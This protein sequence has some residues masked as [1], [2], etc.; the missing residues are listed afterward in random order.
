MSNKIIIVSNRLPISVK[1]NNGKFKYERTV[2]GLASGLDSVQKLHK[3]T[4]VGWPGTYSYKE[5]KGEQKKIKSQLKSKFNYHP[6]FQS[7]ID[8]EKYYH[9][10]S[11]STLWPLFHYFTQN[12]VYDRSFWRTYKKVNKLFFDEVIRIYESGDTIWIHDYHLMMLPQMLRE[13]L[14]KATIGF[15]L[16]IPFPS[17]EI[18]RLLPQREEVLRGLLG[19][20]VVGF[21]TY[22]Y[23]RHFLTSIYRLLGY[24]HHLGQIYLGDRVIKA[25]AFPIGIDFDKFNKAHDSARVQKETAKLEKKIGDYKVILS[26]DRLDYTKG[27]ARR[28]EAFNEFLERYPK[29]KEK[30]ILILVVVPSRT[31]INEYLMMKKQI[32]ELIGNINGKYGDLDWTPVWYLYKG[33]DFPELVALYRVADVCLVTPLRDGMNLIAKEYIASKTQGRGVL[34]LSEMVGAAE[35]LNEALIINP[36]NRSEIIEAIKEA[37][38]MPKYEQ[39]KRIHAIQRELSHFNE[40]LWSKNFMVRLAETKKLQK[41]LQVK[42]VGPIITKEIKDSYQKSKKRLLLLDY[43]GTLTPFV[44]SP[45]EA[46]PDE[47]LINLLKKLES[48]PKN[49][50]VIISG[51]DRDTLDKWFGDLDIGLVAEHGV[52]IRENGNKWV[53]PEEL[54]SDWKR[55]IR[56]ILDRYVERTPGSFV[57]EK[58]FS[59]VW[60]YRKVDPALG[61]VRKRE[62]I[63]VLDDVTNNFNL[64]I[65]DGNK[66]I[67]IKSAS[68]NKG[69]VVS[70]WLAKGKWDFIIALGDDTTDEDTFSV[71]PEKAFSIKVGL[72]QSQAHFNLRSIKEVRPLLRE[73]K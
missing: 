46:K 30:V 32:D 62:L 53:M 2:G 34:I 13:K 31:K 65:L 59:L 49:K 42:V 7:Q 38:T 57:E 61:P 40:K 25:D 5:D 20:D 1:K 47:D 6:V 58:A 41:D 33:L 19:A 21:Q 72:G 14:P 24:D 37:L 73:L 11:N 43:D 54:S 28:L 10:Y 23:T 26:I 16:H 69:R 64:R 51:R 56:P 50:V 35:E 27:I 52:W 15:F 36:N 70:H 67:E 45:E 17:Y 60:H 63:S 71:L 18:F 8:V 66:V 68:V 4:W 3:S 39:Q 48:D 9:G 29:Y 44:G 22:E 12:A 55:E